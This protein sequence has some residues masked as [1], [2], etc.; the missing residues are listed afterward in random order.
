MSDHR[1]GKDT[2]SQSASPK[3]APE[4]VIGKRSRGGHLKK[5]LIMAVIAASV[6]GMLV[7][8][9]LPADRGRKGSSEGDAVYAN[10]TMPQDVREM[11]MKLPEVKITPSSSAPQSA[12]GRT[13]GIKD[14]F[15]GYAVRTSERTS[16]AQTTSTEAASGA[17]KDYSGMAQADARL[18][19]ERAARRAPMEVATKL[20]AGLAVAQSQ[21][22]SNINTQGVPV[23]AASSSPTPYPV[24]GALVSGVV[25]QVTYTPGEIYRDLNDQKTKLEFSV[26]KAESA[27]SNVAKPADPELLPFTI[28]PGTIIPAAL[29]TGI[30]TDL[31]GDVLATVTENVYDS[32]SGKNLLI[33]QGSKLL[34]KY[35]SAISFGQNRVQVAWQR[36]I[37][38]DGVSLQMGNMNGVDPQGASGYAGYVDEH[39]WE[40]AKGIGL[41]LLFSI[42]DGQIQ[43]SMKEANTQGSTDVANSLTA[44]LDQVGSQ[45]TSNVMNIQPTITVKQ[46]SK[47]QVFVNADLIMPPANQKAV[48][49]KYSIPKDEGGTQ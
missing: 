27:A 46:G 7:L 20:T 29:Q 31:P 36:L 2:S 21:Q 45:Y 25:P 32:V 16:S 3:A 42:I 30:N 47:V 34:A 19:E 14:P 12:F 26:S 33:P 37:R 17:G 35:S 44:G 13:S 22:A 41:M 5:R 43:Y 40:Y 1:K 18:E 4:A 23:V 39:W 38:P 28:F 24:Q 6:I 49:K 48:A 10:D 11:A 9:F 8:N 15:A